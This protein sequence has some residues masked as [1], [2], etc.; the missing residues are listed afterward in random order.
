V[1]I[2]IG[3]SRAGVIWALPLLYRGG[4]QAQEPAIYSANGKPSLSKEFHSSQLR[5]NVSHSGGTVLLAFGLDRELGVDVEQIRP[6]FATGEVAERFF[7]AKEVSALRSLPVALQAEAFFNCWTRKEA[8]IKAIGQGL[9]CPLDR[10][11][12]TLAPGEPARLVATSVADVPV[13]KWS[14]RSLNCQPG[15]KAALVVEGHDWKLR[16]WKWRSS[17]FL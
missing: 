13:S 1:R 14:M 15:L 3:A 17:N 16:C 12:V 7:S 8:F 6:D 9:S 4:S 5:F 2:E 10:F 11:E